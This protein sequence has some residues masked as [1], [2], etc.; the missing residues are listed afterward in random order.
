MR[1][2]C[3]QKSRGGSSVSFKNS[4]IYKTQC[5]A[6]IDTGVSV[7]YHVLVLR[8]FGVH[9]LRRCLMFF[10]SLLASIPEWIVFAS[11][12]FI[13]HIGFWIGINIFQ[14]PEQTLNLSWSGHVGDFGLAMIVAMGAGVLHRP[15][16]SLPG[17]IVSPY[18]HLACIAVA[19][20]CGYILTSPSSPLPTGRWSDWYHSW[21]MVPFLV[22]TVTTTA[23]VILCAGTWIEIVATYGLFIIWLA[24]VFFDGKTGR[25]NQPLWRYRHNIPW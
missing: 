7:M 15:G 20:V 3:S 17:F 6:N 19:F 21:V 2:K 14:G 11:V 13:S 16:M 18:F 25:L 1:R 9:L 24:L 12:I 22:Y 23:S 4:Q 8:A 10:Y 5:S